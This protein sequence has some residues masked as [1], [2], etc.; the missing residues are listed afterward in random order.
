MRELLDKNGEKEKRIKTNQVIGQKRRE[1][2]ALC[3]SV[4][5]RS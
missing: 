1:I 4:F 3:H 2:C 5:W